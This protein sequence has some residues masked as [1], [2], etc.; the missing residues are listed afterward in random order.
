MAGSLVV[1][2][3]PALPM[4][5]NVALAADVVVPV[6]VPSFDLRYPQE[7]KG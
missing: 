5:T 6:V 4:T 2:R 1:D 7:L 3:F